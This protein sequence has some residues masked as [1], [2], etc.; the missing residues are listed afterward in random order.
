MAL[1]RHRLATAVLLSGKSPTPIVQQTGWAP[2]SG[3]D[4]YG[5]E[6]VCFSHRGT[7]PETPNR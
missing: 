3:L 5:N 1:G 4:G 7:K 2:I 6:K